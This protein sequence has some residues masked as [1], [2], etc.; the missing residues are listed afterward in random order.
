METNWRWAAAAKAGAVLLWTVGQFACADEGMWLFNDPPRKLLA[1]R[2]GFEPADAWLERVQKASVRF[3]NGGSGSFVSAEGLI[4]SNHHVGADAV[5]KLSG[6]GRDYLKDGFL[7]RSRSDELPC[8][9][10]ELNVLMSIEDV[11]GRVNA[12][13]QAGMSP[14]DAF[15][16]RRAVMAAIEQE[17]LDQTGLRSDVVTLFQG[18]RYHLY[19]YK[20]YT[21][22]RLV[23]S[24]E[25]QTA[26]FGG[27]PDNFEYPRYCL[28]MVL[29]R[30]YEDG[31]PA[32][33]E[34]FLKWNVRG[35]AE[36]ELVFVSGHPGRTGR[37]LTM[38]ELAYDRDSRLPYTLERLYNLEV[39]L[40]AYSARGAENERRAKDQLLGVQNGR[41]AL[42]GQLAGLLDPGVIRLKAE[43]EEALRRELSSSERWRPVLDAW[44]RIQAAQTVIA[45][46]ALEYRLLEAGH[47]FGGELFDIARTLARADDELPKPNGERLSEFRDSAL[48]SLKLGLFSEK[49]I[50][51]DLEQLLLSESLTWFATKLGPTHAIVQSVLEDKSPRERAAELI[52][53]SQVGKVDVR[54]KL[55][56]GGRESIAAAKDPMIEL[57]LRIDDASRAVRKI[58]E[59]QDELKQQAHAK[60]AE[61]RFALG[62]TS[63]YPDATFTLRLAFGTIAGYL[64]QGEVLPYQTRIQGL[65]ERAEAQHLRSPF[66]LPARWID[67]KSDLDLSTP[68]NFVSTCDIIGGNSGSPVINRNGELVGLI[69][70]GN[71]HSLVLDHIYT[72]EQARAISVHPA[73]MVEALRKVYNAPDLLAEILGANST[74]E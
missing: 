19:R 32:R 52:L 12:A 18:G 7:A 40:T 2:Y 51:D 23:F 50:H 13:V 45:Q 74:A 73:A 66:D 33:T 62:G 5:Q 42:R 37:S 67:R 31:R 20:R 36:G 34:H 10:L 55:F 58:I 47:A 65:Y 14:E 1:E 29:F 57:A 48:E 27:D 68:I 17:S 11:T 28:D 46:H 22:V 3:N 61:A 8:V 43:D 41:K 30:A 35:A 53:R 38:A 16:A 64:D 26:F 39:I 9:D 72:E 56:D 60:I 70:D 15:R 21:D 54:R 6:A 69:F 44:D 63:R 71:I 59:A 49:P 4:L 24:P 25:Q